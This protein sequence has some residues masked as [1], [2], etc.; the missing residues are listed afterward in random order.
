M[1]VNSRALL[2]L[3]RILT[4]I[5]RSKYKILMGTGVAGVHSID[6]IDYAGT[7]ADSDQYLLFNRTL[8]LELPIN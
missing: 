6:T 8:I 1:I 7:E 2:Q 3:A 4:L 5:P